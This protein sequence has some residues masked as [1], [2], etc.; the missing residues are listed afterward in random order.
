MVTYLVFSTTAH[1]EPHTLLPKDDIGLHIEPKTIDFAVYF[2]D[3]DT[4][5]KAFDQLTAR[6]SFSKAS[7]NHTYA[8]PLRRRPI[9]MSI[10]T[11]LTGREWR[12]ARICI[13]TWVTAQLNKLEQVVAPDST[14]L[15]EL[16]FLP[17]IIIQGYEWRFLA[18]TRSGGETVCL[19]LQ[20]IVNSSS[21]CTGPLGRHISRLDAVFSRDVFDS[22]LLAG[23]GEMVPRGLQAVVPSAC[24]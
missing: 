8:T 18:F 2:E 11:T 6:N 19:T 24:H 7:W 1:I 9:A 20:N 3:D 10:V 13:I 23:I 22:C 21:Q 4:M 14:G 17:V 5:S 16:P 15:S 12:E